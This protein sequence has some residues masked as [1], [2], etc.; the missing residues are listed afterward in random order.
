MLLVCPCRSGSTI[1][2]RAF[3]HAGVPA[4]FQPIKNAL[5]WGL[6]GEWRPWEMPSDVDLQTVFVK[7]TFGPY[8]PEETSFDPL[9][10]LLDAGLPADRIILV[11]LLRDPAAVWS[12]WQTYWRGQ[13]SPEL[14]A[15]AWRA[16]LRCVTTARAHGVRV[17]S[18]RHETLSTD[19]LHE[20]TALFEM[21]HLNFPPEALECWGE[22]PGF[23]VIGSGVFLPDEPEVF[24]TPGVHDPVI[25]ARSIHPVAP[26]CVADEADRILLKRTGVINSYEALSHELSDCVQNRTIDGKDCTDD[27]R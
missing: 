15:A 12:S 7:E 9:S 24:I 14:F 4:F 25:A 26:H 11:V 21:L 6:Q 8:H 10:C 16:C 13:T 18:L 17:Q 27:A 23:G 5:R 1:M 2:L 20:M 3:G 22:K 19:P